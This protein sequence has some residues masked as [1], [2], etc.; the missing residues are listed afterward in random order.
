MKVSATLSRTALRLGF[1]GRRW[2]V[3]REFRRYQGTCG[4]EWSGAMLLAGAAVV[5]R[6]QRA[7]MKVSATLRRTV[8][9]LGSMGRRHIHGFC[10][11]SSLLSLCLILPGFAAAPPLPSNQQSQSG[12]ATPNVKKSAVYPRGMKLMLTDGTFQLVR[13][14]QRNGDHVQVFQ[15]GARCVGGVAGVHGGLGGDGEDGSGGRK[16]FR[17][18]GGK[19]S[20]SRKK[21]DTWTT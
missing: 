13:E 1:L 18:A 14:Y 9:C 10:F 17:G 15:R 21:R 8:W 12:T 4:L 16:G 19:S 6:V 5:A 7:D 20:T 3:G 11:C 2:I